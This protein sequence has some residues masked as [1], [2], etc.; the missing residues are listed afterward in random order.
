MLWKE[1][2]TFLH[3]K[4]ARSPNYGVWDHISRKS[5]AG[6][7]RLQV[8]VASPP[9][10][11]SKFFTLT[12]VRSILDCNSAWMQRLKGDLQMHTHWSDGS[13]SIEEMSDAGEA[14][15]YEYLA[16]T[17]HAKGLKIAGS[18]N[19]E[20]LAQ[21]ADELAD[22][23]G[24]VSMSQRSIRVL[25]SIELNLNPPGVVDMYLASFANLDIVLRCF[26]N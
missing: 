14:N 7:L 20:Q 10:V 18:I 22:I 8:F 15:G 25:R 1:E 11:R 6:G 24:S 4:G 16:I 19:E 3:Q 5:F 17:D 2:A 9:P 12:G 26:R 21:Q 23:N 13:S